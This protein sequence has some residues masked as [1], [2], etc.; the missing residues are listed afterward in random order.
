MDAGSI[1]SQ[2]TH[3]SYQSADTM[4]Q[5][6]ASAP[7]SD[8]PLVTRTNRYPRNGAAAFRAESHRHHPNQRTS[9][10]TTQRPNQY[11]EE[12]DS[13]SGYSPSEEDDYSLESDAC[14]L[15]SSDLSLGSVE[16][17]RQPSTRLRS[18]IQSNVQLR[19]ATSQLLNR[20]TQ[21][22]PME[23]DEDSEREMESSEAE[24][25]EAWSD[26]GEREEARESLPLHAMAQEAGV[27]HQTFFRILNGG[28][29]E[30]A[31]EH[32]A[33]VYAFFE[34]ELNRILNTDREAISAEVATIIRNPMIDPTTKVALTVSAEEYKLLLTGIQQHHGNNAPSHRAQPQGNQNLP[35]DPQ[36]LKSFYY[37]VR[38]Y[39]KAKSA[40]QA[41]A[42]QHSM[43][44]SGAVR[45]NPAA[46]GIGFADVAGAEEAKEDLKNVVHYL[47]HP[48]AYIRMGAKMP[49]GIL[50][51]GPPGTGKTLLAKAVAGEAKVPFFYISASNFDE[52]YVGTGAKR[53][54]Q[55]FQEAREVQPAII[56]ID[57]ID[58]VGKRRGGADEDNH[59]QTLNQIL[60]E[61]DGFS[62]TDEV[63]VLAAT[64]RS[65]TLDPALVRPGRFDRTINVPLPLVKERAEVLKIHLSK[66]QH[67][68]TDEDVEKVALTTRSF[69]G[70]DLARVVNDAALVVVAA[71][72][73][74]ITLSDIE[75]SIDKLVM[76]GEVRQL[77]MAEKDVINTAYHEAGHTLVGML[78][79][80]H[81]PIDKVTILP[82]GKSLGHTAILEDDGDGVGQT[83]EQLLAEITMGMGGRVAEELAFGEGQVTTGASSDLVF[84]TRIAYS[85]V[86]KW[87][88]SDLGPVV[89]DSDSARL[90]QMT[91]EMAAKITEEVSKIVNS[92]NAEAKQL[93]TTHREKLETLKDALLERETMSGAEVKSLV[94]L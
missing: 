68:L 84:V 94:G 19:S 78:L 45:V 79:P 8:N 37:L 12:S 62:S 3:A 52:I 71:D 77:Q 5:S 87:G 34:G 28:S 69:S 10:R 11:L 59:A 44:Q 58:A 50:L 56:F 48:D 4:P 81:S 73:E 25:D 49:K 39:D 6:G 7:R 14:S 46:M 40:A 9:Q 16:R 61:L 93:L 74:Q 83:R 85:M 1:H 35:I 29:L 90:P 54:R 32:W 65:E 20:L 86:T 89:L 38:R 64:N 55:L 80:E 23:L 57:E 47:K 22:Q 53:A 60:T 66:V 82:R 2:S 75:T 63:I 43:G 30:R 13:V 33:S 92:C 70:A 67:T 42:R 31:N 21:A 51:E 17:E 88:F 41:T 36:A 72:R 76:G 15:A 24:G 18:Q 26:A 27:D 91:S